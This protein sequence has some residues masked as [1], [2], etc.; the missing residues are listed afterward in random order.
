M[1]RSLLAVSA[2]S[3][4]ALL[5][6]CGASTSPTTSPPTA[7]RAAVVATPTPPPAATTAPAGALSG[8]WTGQYSGPFTGTFTLTWTQ[9][10]VGPERHPLN[11]ESPRQPQHQWERHGHRHHVRLR[12]RG[13][14]FGDGLRQHHVRQLSGS[15]R[16]WNRFLERHKVLTGSP[17]GCNCWSA[18]RALT[19]GTPGL[20]Q[21]E[22]VRARPCTACEPRARLTS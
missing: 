3:G 13:H 10:G 4:I 19:S 5:S 22:P 8:T 6:A 12:G 7:T 21:H 15:G 14:L 1:V 17:G 11:L 18:T 9:S 20:T 16:A 2:V